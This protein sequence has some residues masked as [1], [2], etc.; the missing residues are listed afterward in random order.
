MESAKNG[1]KA[2]SWT[3]TIKKHEQEAKACL[4]KGRIDEAADAYR[5][6]G[7]ACQ[8]SSRTAS[9]VEEYIVFTKHAIKAYEE[10]ANLFRQCS[11]AA[12][13]LECKAEILL[14][15]GMLANSALKAKQA[16]KQSYERFIEASELYSREND[17]ESLA[18]ILGRAAW[19]LSYV[20]TLSSGQEELE[21][22]YRE[23]RHVADEAWRLSRDVGNFQS[24]AES[25]FAESMLSWAEMFAV[26]FRWDEQWR[27]YWKEFLQKC[28]TSMNLAENCDD[29]LVL[30]TIYGWAGAWN[31]F[32]GFQFV[33]DE[34]QQREFADEGLN[35]LEKALMYADSTGDK[36]LKIICLFWLDFLGV[37]GGRFE[38]L[39]TRIFND[40]QEVVEL[41]RTY[42]DS[43]TAWRHIAYVLPALCYANLAQRSFVAPEQRKSFAEIAIEYSK[44]GLK[45]LVLGPITALP[46]QTLTWSHSQLAI[47]AVTKKDRSE[48]AEKMVEYARKA[49]E[50]ADKFEGGWTKAAG[51]SSL[52]RAYKTLADITENKDEKTRM[53]TDATDA[54][55][56]YINH[57]LESRTGIILAEM[58]LGLL[59]QELGATTGETE[60]LIEAKKS[61]IRVIKESTERGYP[62]YEAAAH[63]CTAHIEDQLGSHLSSADHYEKAQ[64]AH[65]ISLKDTLYEPLKERVQE[66]VDY[67]A[68]WGLIERAK[69]HQKREAH[70]EAKANYRKASKILGKLKRYSYE[71]QYY[72]AWALLEDAEQLSKQ[73][74]HKQTAQKYEV[75]REEFEKATRNL[76]EVLTQSMD[77]VERGRVE[78]LVKLARARMSYCSARAQ[79]EGARSLGKQG[80]H[81]EAAER[82]AHAAS[83]FR[84]VFSLIS[85]ER[86]RGELEA[87]YNLCRAWET[88]ELAEEYQDPDR[89]S[90]A[91]KLFTKASKIFTESNL[92]ALASGNSAF[93]QALEYGCKFD[94]STDAEVKTEL[95]TRIKSKLRRAS[96]SYQKAGYESGANW[97]LA[98]STYFDAIWHLMKADEELDLDER[99]KLL[100]IGNRYLKSAAELFGQAGYENKEKD[101]LERLELLEKE[102]SIL[103]SALD[104]L[105]DSSVSKS[106]L[107]IIAPASSVESSFS[108][109]ISDV[110]QYTE[111]TLRLSASTPGSK[112]AI[113]YRDLLKE[114]PQVERKECR[115]GIAQ[116]GISENADFLNENYEEKNRGLLGLREEKV[117]EVRSKVRSMIDTAHSEGVEILLFPE[118]AIDLNYEELLEDILNLA[119]IN[120]MYI[121]P[122]SYHDLE[123]RRNI[124][125]VIGP[126]GILWKQEKHIPATVQIEGKRFKEQIDVGSFP[127]KTIV[128][129]TQFG[130]IAIVICR[131]FLDMDLRV[132]LKN[133][134][135]P[136]DIILNPA[137]TPTF[138]DF[139]AVHF[140]ARRSIYAY[141]FFANMA[142]F[143][144][145]LI[146]TPE[147][148]RVK[149]EMPPGE[150]G[151]L[152]KDVDVFKLRSERKKWERE[153]RKERQFIQST[154]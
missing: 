17:R 101:V 104:T 130:R 42:D 15:N 63:I 70:A 105:L 14:E 52:Y 80:K 115:V 92:K 121:V 132:E 24:M 120:G 16:F 118:L 136:V 81:L 129:N 7:H 3:K 106:A 48:H 73:E 86:E 88:M 28:N 127:K 98:T 72:S 75:A 112:F 32:F 109:R 117:E 65:M 19:A 22:L 139:E 97:A 12:N 113:V 53:L 36:P 103:V 119:N 62:F 146:N 31:W 26:T 89:F 57:A 84:E 47:L 122:G 68:A 85:I 34:E 100:R 135:P 108:P 29:L 18:R 25:L 6:L 94:N 79:I 76:E 33:E 71:A 11:K 149:R 142:A 13:H 51:Y 148:E 50:S 61:F 10:A 46:Y 9:K 82:F 64:N 152:Y 150:E 145:S 151:L 56:R 43:F 123:T 37:V 140:D 134:E 40:L 41:G 1:K 83:Q 69:S 35:L 77:K 2:L 102:E 91:V 153:Q 27:E 67:S 78:K 147:K 99:R 45:K 87:I 141:C 30:G 4:E 96:S 133:S 66:L 143:G 114:H 111:G 49:E 131:D 39:Q 55:K 90:E 5:K 95:Y 110:R 116:I 58:R 59:Y 20:V 93:C 124:S 8:H 38:Y 21:Q 74:K 126:E 138:A 23:G 60:P 144:G 125:V 44:E 107:G 137:F 154:R 128:C 54:H